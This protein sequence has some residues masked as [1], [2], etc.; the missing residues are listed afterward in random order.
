MRTVAICVI[1][2]TLV[3][4]SS[5]A[6]SSAPATARATFTTTSGTF[7]TAI[8]KVASTD[9]ER[10]QGLMNV[11][12]LA[13]DTGMAFV[14]D[15]PTTATFWMKDTI[16]PLSIAFWDAQGRIVDILEMT[17][18]RADPCP[19]YTARAPYTTA[20]EMNAGWY[21]RHGVQIGDHVE[22]GVHTQ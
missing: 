19:T 2:L 3:A 18:C 9:T 13:P 12:T 20:L 6:R 11:Q 22:F 17:P 5:A 7:R 16:I 14:F 21:E 15:G 10:A 8:L 4:C 1:G